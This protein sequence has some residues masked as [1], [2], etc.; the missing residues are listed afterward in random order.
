MSVT[1]QVSFP[2]EELECP[3]CFKLLAEPCAV[4]CS[5]NFCRLCLQRTLQEHKPLCP[6]CRSDISFLNPNDLRTN[7]LLQT[8]LKS[9]CGDKY[10]ERLR[11]VDEERK[12]LETSVRVVKKLY[13]GNEHETTSRGEETWHRWTLFVRMDN[14]R[15]ASE[16]IDNVVVKL[17]PTFRPDTV[18]LYQPPF[19][20]S[21]LGWG[22]FM[23]RIKI[24]FKQQYHKAPLEVSHMLSFTGNGNMRSEDIEFV[25]KKYQ[26][27]MADHASAEEENNDDW[28]DIDDDEEDEE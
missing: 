25:T 17:H 18:T 13:I 4:P 19:E 27:G 8:I 28:E 15:D 9:I 11:E 3:L 23:I 5:H 6:V 21:R 22:I 7:G 2:E 20:V 1:A 14:D 16:Y 26:L 10:E 24:N 12:E